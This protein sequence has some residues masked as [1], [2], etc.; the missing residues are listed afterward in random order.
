MYSENYMELPKVV[1]RHTRLHWLRRRADS[2]AL[3]TTALDV[4]RDA[5]ARF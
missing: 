1:E 4:M 5:N 3:L 2:E